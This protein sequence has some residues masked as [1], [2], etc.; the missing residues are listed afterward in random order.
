MQWRNVALSVLN[1]CLGKFLKALWFELFYRIWKTWYTR[2][3]VT[4]FSCDILK[5]QY[6]SITITI[7]ALNKCSNFRMTNST[8]DYFKKQVHCASDHWN[9]SNNIKLCPV[10]RM[11]LNRWLDI[12]RKNNDKIKQTIQSANLSTGSN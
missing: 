2:L 8:V 3:K 12:L 9:L 11:L 1:F 7:R 6:N 5:P 10:N 4:S